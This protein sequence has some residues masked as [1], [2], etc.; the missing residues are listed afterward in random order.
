MTAAE[1]WPDD[2]VEVARVADA[3]GVKGWIRV[4]PFSQE[5]QALLAAQQWFLKAPDAAPGAP[6]RPLPPVLHVA[7][8]R[9]HGDAVVASADGVA[10]RTAAE[11]LKGARIFVS[12][13]SFPEADADEYY[14]VDLIGLAV[15]NR[16]GET[17]GTVAD[18]LDTGAQSVLR[19]LEPTQPSPTE[20]LIP[21]VSA[22]VD[23]VSLEQRKITVDWGRDY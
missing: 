1:A 11:A 12:R 19:V 8:A 20:R 7:S 6:A 2:A 16:E 15:V 18:L 21:F 9:R 3:W 22:Y 13:S 5:P 4:Q 23:E 14:W 10:D 17:L